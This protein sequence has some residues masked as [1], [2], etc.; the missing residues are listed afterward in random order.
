MQGIEPK[1]RDFVKSITPAPWIPNPVAP[2]GTDHAPKNN[3][4]IELWTDGN[5]AADSK[6]IH[7]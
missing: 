5:S 7:R 1:P 4:I 3:S 2:T 6:Q